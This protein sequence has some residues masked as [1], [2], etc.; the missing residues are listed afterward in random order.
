MTSIRFVYDGCRATT[1]RPTLDGWENLG[2]WGHGI[3]DGRYCRPHADALEQILLE[4]ALDDPENDCSMATEQKACLIIGCDTSVQAEH[5]AKTAA[6]LLPRH[7]RAVL[8]RMKEPTAPRNPSD[9]E[10]EP[11]LAFARGFRG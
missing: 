10:L 3:A 1:E 5:A 6:R 7:R 8:E 2:A 4:G 9:A 11:Y